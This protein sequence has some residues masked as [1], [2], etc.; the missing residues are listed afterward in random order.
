MLL[1]LVAGCSAPQ[2]A[3]RHEGRPIRIVS[4]NPCTDA[5]LVELVDKDRIAAVSHYSLK[6]ESSS[7][8]PDKVAGITAIGD[9]AEETV[10]LRP[11]LVLAASH[12]SAATRGAIAASGA[13]VVT[14]GV[15]MNVDDSIAQIREVADAVGEKPRGEALVARI[16]S[17]RQAARSRAK[18]LPALIWQGSGL[19]PGQGTLADEMLGIAGFSNANTLYG[20]QSWD[21]L[22]LEKLAM[23]PPAIVF[24]PLGAE[25]DEGD[26][27][28]QAVRKRLFGR[29]EN[30]TRIVNFP[31]RL[32]YCGG[33]T[34]V[35]ALAALS[36]VRS[37]TP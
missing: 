24:T 4:T 33:P 27:R 28:S 23:R 13:K 19:V 1:L 5:I 25:G 12:M 17:A 8:T 16:E 11:D 26:A 10:A 31:P 20:L 36:I 29:M 35:D 22:P 21:I 34:I 32:L 14:L 37:G 18:P 6:P 7:T 9:T 15:P 2:P 3:A 30:N